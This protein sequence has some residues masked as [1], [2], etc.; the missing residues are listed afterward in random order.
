MRGSST[1][2]VLCVLLMIISSNPLRAI[3]PRQSLVP[4]VLYVASRVL[5]VPLGL[6]EVCVSTER[7][8]GHP[9]LKKKKKKKKGDKSC[10]SLFNILD[11]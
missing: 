1:G 5:C 10:N 9:R 3:Y 7:W 4:I 6:V 8:L 2:L 11:L